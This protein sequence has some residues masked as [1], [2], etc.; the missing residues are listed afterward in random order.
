MWYHACMDFATMLRTARESAG[1][2]QRR[3]ARLA[4]TSQAAVSCYERGTVSP[5]VRTLTRLLDACGRG[6]AP[7]KDSRGAAT[8]RPVLGRF[9][10]TAQEWE[11]RPYFMWSSNTSWREVVSALR[12]SDVSRRRAMLAAVLDDAKWDDIWRLASPG[13]IARDLGAL[14]VR[15]KST[16]RFFLEHTAL[17]S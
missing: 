1:L 5:S 3:L 13:L 4:G 8:V 7:T 9:P 10:M 16:W 11:C 17:A 6:P 14:R 2:S 12:S 15:R